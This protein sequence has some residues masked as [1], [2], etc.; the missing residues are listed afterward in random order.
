MVIT[1]EGKE[2]EI[3]VVCGRVL[4]LGID[5]V[6]EMVN[7][8]SGEGVVTVANHNTPQ[9]IVISGNMAALDTVS[10]QLEE[11]GAKVIPL[12]VSIAN[13]SP[14]VA[15]AA[16]DFAEFMQ[17]VTFHKPEI[18]VY[19]NVSAVCE[20]DPAVIKQMMA[21]QI[22]SRVRWCEIIISMLNDGVDTF[23]EVGPKNVLKGMMRKIV[24]K[25][26]KVTSV[27]FDT[28]EALDTCIRKIG[29]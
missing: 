23:I 7:S 19:F 26:K 24:P 10:V 25:G 13:H 9:Q 1:W 4:G 28:P 8:Y 16:G 5:D 17:G 2:H 22:A 21:R 14:L 11:K 29:L 27:Q 20:Y 12:N 6:E 3:R 18:P 15:Q